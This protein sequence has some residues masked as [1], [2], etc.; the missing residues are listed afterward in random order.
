GAPYAISLT[1]NPSWVGG[2]QRARLT[3]RLTD[4]YGNGEPDQPLSFALV[5]GT[6]TITP[7][8]AT[9]LAD[10][11]ARADFQSP[12]NPETDRIRATAGSI[13]KDLDLLTSSTD[14][15]APGC[16]VTNFPNPFHPPQQSTTIIYKLDDV[17]T[18][19]LRIFTLGGAPVLERT[20]ARGATGGSVGENSFAW[21]GRNGQGDVVGSGGYP[22]LIEAPG[23]GSTLPVIRRQVAV[24]R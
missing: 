11:S 7:I 4:F 12:R 21:D 2:N 6:G 9:T 1:S 15:H 8:D 17:A 23:G 20:F 3:A 13:T 5:S 16:Y 10:G 22:I 18:V 24:V 14:P 19:T